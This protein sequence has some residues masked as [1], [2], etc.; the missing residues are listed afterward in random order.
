MKNYKLILGT[1]SIALI[2]FSCSERIHDYHA[3]FIIDE[4]GKPIDSA[5]IYED[6]AENYVIKT[7]SDSTG[8]FKQKRQ[9]LMDLIVSKE[10]YLTDTIRMVWHQAG[11]TTEYSTLVKTD[12]SKVV[13]KADSS[14]QKVTII[15]GFYSICCGTP[16]GEEI[17]NY[18]GKFIQHHDLKNVKITLVG[19]LG[20]EGEHDFLIEIPAITKMQKVVFL[21]NLK[22]LAKMAPK[23]NSDGGINVSESENIKE[24]YANR[25]RVTFKEIDLKSL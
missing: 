20:K 5:L 21:K 25:S 2:S 11:E 3:G 23:T 1:I 15:L 19:G 8:Y 13:L 4:Q 22:N 12:S 24:R 14:V 16:N 7:Y 17:L 10:G 6:L 9:S 18:A